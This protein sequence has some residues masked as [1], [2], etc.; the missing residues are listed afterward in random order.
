M[1]S[2]YSEP[3]GEVPVL[4]GIPVDANGFY[5]SSHPNCLI[6]FSTGPRPEGMRVPAPLVVPDLSPKSL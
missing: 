3:A 2:S 1:L 6:I 4:I 5:A